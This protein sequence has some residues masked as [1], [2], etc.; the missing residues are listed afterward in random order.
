M[1]KLL[2]SAAALM[3]FASFAMA[4]SVTE[5]FAAA[6]TQDWFGVTNKANTVADVTTCTSAETGIS[7]SYVYT[8]AAKSNGVIMQ[9][10][11]NTPADAT[12]NAYLA[13]TLKFD[14]KEIVLLTGKTA[15]TAAVVNVYAGETL[16]KSDLALNAQGTEFTVVIPDANSAAGTVIKIE[17]I[18]AK[19]AQLESITYN[20]ETN[21]KPDPV[22][23]TP[24]DPTPAGN[25]LLDVPFTDGLDGGFTLGNEGAPLEIWKINN[26]G[27]VASGYDS[28]AKERFVT[29]SWAVSPVIDTNGYTSLTL[30]FDWAGNFFTTVEN[31]QNWVEVAVCE[32]GDDWNELTVPTW[33]TGAAWTFVKSGDI[34]LTAY[35]G[36]KIKIGFNYAS[37]GTTED[38]GT[39]E[40]Q[41]VKL[42]GEGGA[43]VAVVEAEGAAEY[44]NLQGVR[45]ANPD[46]GLYI[47]V[48]GGKAT[49]E[50]I[51]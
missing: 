27:L 5:N 9:G 14:T 46:K 40:I 25:Y 12:V 45:V 32:D 18:S 28:A 16:I 41:N 7:Y 22:D 36:K 42:S 30:S 50:V 43:N 48:R 4:E 47:V 23:P 1:K 33:P 35:A 51:K 13:C 37:G 6:E 17:N 24:V 15:S 20:S 8:Y 29:D 11:A 49:K 34:D 2:L 21:G 44:Y 39:L 38:T 10:T 26:Y 3:G 19:N 31:M